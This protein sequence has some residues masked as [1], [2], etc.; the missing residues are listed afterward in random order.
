MRAPLS[1]II[2]TLD[3]AAGLPAALAALDEARAED[4]LC[5][6][7]VVDGGSADA[8]VALART[9]QARIIDAPRCRGAQLAAGGASAAGDWL[10]FLH[11]D[12]RLARGWST[13]VLGFIAHPANRAR[14]GYLRFC[15][16]DRARRPTPRGRGAMA[17]PPAGAAFWRAR[18]ADAGGALPPARRLPAAAVD[19]G[20]R[21]GATPRPLAPRRARD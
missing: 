9:A 8:T 19:G 10:L 21:P 20:C 11:A 3:A 16:D 1:V 7:L 4:L 5:E 15:L 17:L 18:S 13:H 2:P 14:A 6:V 12:T